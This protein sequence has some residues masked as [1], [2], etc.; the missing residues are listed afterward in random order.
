MKKI[1]IVVSV[2][3]IPFLIKA[4]V[5]TDINKINSAIKTE[6]PPFEKPPHDSVLS[7]EMSFNRIRDNG[8][9]NRTVST[10]ISD[11]LIDTLRKA[12]IGFTTP[13]NVYY[14]VDSV[15]VNGNK[16]YVK[17]KLYNGLRHWLNNPPTWDLVKTCF[18]ENTSIGHILLMLL[19]DEVVKSD[20][21]TTTYGPIL[22]EIIQRS[23]H[24][25]KF[26]WNGGYN[27]RYNNTDTTRFISIGQLVSSNP[28]RLANLGYRLY[29]FMG[30][31]AATGDSLMMDTISRMVKNQLPY[32]INNPSIV[33]SSADAVQGFLYDGSTFQH[34]QQFMN[35]NYGGDGMSMLTNFNT[36]T[37]GTVWEF[38][39]TE[40]TIWARLAING[41]PW[42]SWKKSRSHNMSGRSNL[43][44]GHLNGSAYSIV[45]S[46]YFG[47]ANNATG[48]PISSNLPVWDTVAYIRRKTVTPESINLP[49]KV[50]R[51]IDSSKYF[52][53]SHIILQQTP[54]FFTSV[55]MLS[56]RVLGIESSDA[57][58][59]A[60]KQNFHMADGSCFIYRGKADSYDTALVG[61]NYRCIPGITAKQRSGSLPLVQWGIG[62][63]SNNSLAG[64]ISDGNVS[65]G[66]FYLDRT[67]ASATTKAFKSYFTFKDAV[68][69][70]GN[71]VNDGNT[72]TGNV[73]T[74]INQVSLRTDIFYNINSTGINSLLNGQLDTLTSTIS[75]TSWFWHDSTGYIVIPASNT[76]PTEVILMAGTRSGNWR[77]LDNLNRNKDTTVNVFQLSINHGGANNANWLS[78]KYA[79]IV[80]PNVDRDSV[81]RFVNRK[82]VARDA[83]AFYLSY[84]DNTKISISYDGYTGIFFLQAGF[85]KATNLGF[86]SINVSSNS[87]AATLIRREDSGLQ[88]RVSDIRNGFFTSNLVKI[89]IN[90][91]LESA[92]I[93]PPYANN[94]VT[95]TPSPLFDSTAINVYTSKTSS[96]YE[97]EPVSVY[98]KYARV[99]STKAR[100]DAFVKNDGQNLNYGYHSYLVA[101]SNYYESF[102]KFNIS[103]KPN[104]DDLIGARLRVYSNAVPNS[105]INWKISGTY[106]D[107]TWREN[108][109]T[110]NNSRNITTGT[111]LNTQSV[112]SN[113][114]YV[115]FNIT[116]FIKN[117][118]PGTQFITLKIIGD[119]GI[120]NSFA[121]SNNTNSAYKPNLEFASKVDNTATNGVVLS[122]QSLIRFN[123]VKVGTVGK[124][125]WLTSNLPQNGYFVIEKSINGN[126]FQPIAT[127]PTSNVNDYT[128]KDSSLYSG[129]I[130]YKLV[131]FNN[132]R[133]IVDE[134]V[135]FLNNTNF[136]DI[137][138]LQVFPNPT[139]N[140][141]TL[142]FA[143]VYNH[144]VVVD[145]FGRIQKEIA[146]IRS[147][148]LLDIST[149]LQGQYLLILSGDTRNRL[150]SKILK[151]N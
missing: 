131:L 13:G 40:K 31:A 24:F 82:I 119:A 29:G 41:F 104:S 27:S 120:Y 133:K 51:S 30:I 124:L 58:S 97:G 28:Q 79:Y 65:M 130:Y 86:D 67:H 108:T 101:Q 71:S 142:K 46:A 139:K 14:H 106:T 34:G 1:L 91:I 54:S 36:R 127:I 126:S 88:M 35:G 110:W 149:L 63:E 18:Y 84:N 116:D 61:F 6:T 12:A 121:S 57:S 55:R 93:N 25:A 90:R 135:A 15:I 115:Y 26:S 68:I 118:P 132:E 42:L 64:G 107:T 140:T 3:L 111:E 145:V 72:S 77:N 50:E 9:F 83:S 59:G 21:T 16:V 70:L 138:S 8:T 99:D 39:N 113:L 128:F 7:Y 105:A 150:S 112:P 23:K 76:E 95:I 103:N 74:T 32:V 85:Q 11:D 56:K 45:S 33:A 141:C 129:G 47:M 92:T 66:M 75:T 114:G 89:G 151:L 48:T 146:A 100:E 148:Y 109:I 122:S 81:Q 4:Q 144:L 38:N 20:L 53:N 49:N 22:R 37:K 52:W 137:K 134:K 10:P 123:S 60:G 19:N 147:P 87:Y 102:L 78:R 96:L 17:R 73:Y 94:P 43:V 117:A 62:T 136:V 143:S 125:S 69:C 44:E 80:L 98:G 2:I 5:V